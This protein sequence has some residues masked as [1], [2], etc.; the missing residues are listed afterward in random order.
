MVS[1]PVVKSKGE[2]NNHYWL[3]IYK[4]LHVFRKN[5]TFIFAVDLLLLLQ[6]RQRARTPAVCCCRWFSASSCDYASEP[7]SGSNLVC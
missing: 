2:G 3:H 1:K 5:S 7:K 4:F 6:N